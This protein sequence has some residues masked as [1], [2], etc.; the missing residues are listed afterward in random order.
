MNYFVQQRPHY[1][2]FLLQTKQLLRHLLLQRLQH[3]KHH[4]QRRVFA[5]LRDVE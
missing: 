5:L 3:L 4:H 1:L 2:L